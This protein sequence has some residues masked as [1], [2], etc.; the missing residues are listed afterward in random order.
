MVSLPDYAWLALCVAAFANAAASGCAAYWLRQ[1][2][3]KR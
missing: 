3:L 2:T 1:L